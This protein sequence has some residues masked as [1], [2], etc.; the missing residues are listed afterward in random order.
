[1]AFYVPVLHSSSCLEPSAHC[2]SCARPTASKSASSA[3][4]R[5]GS[6]RPAAARR[7]SPGGPPR[8]RANRQPARRPSRVQ[9]RARRGDLPGQ[10]RGAAVALRTPRFPR[11]A[12]AATPPC[13]RLPPRHLVLRRRRRLRGRPA[14][15]SSASSRQLGGL[16]PSD[17]VLDVGCGVGRMAMPLT[18]YLDGGSYAGFDVGRGHGP[19]GVSATISPPLAQLRVRLGAR[20]TTASTTR[21]ATSTATEFRFPYEDAQLRLRL[22][23]LALHPFAGTRKRGT[24]WARRHGC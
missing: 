10:G 21:S 20:S 12:G 6:R 8:G 19:A 15:S 7:R 16:E 23:D 13:R 17:R 1:M 22:R 2:F 9:G 14:S 5:A 24:T 3:A 4:A 11:G 18:G